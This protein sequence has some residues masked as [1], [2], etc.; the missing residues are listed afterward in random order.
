[1]V[2]FIFCENDVIYEFGTRFR[3]SFYLEPKPGSSAW[4]D[5]GF[6]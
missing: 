5:P 4:P 3:S 2:I 1:M 6:F